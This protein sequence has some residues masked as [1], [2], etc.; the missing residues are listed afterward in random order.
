MGIVVI[1]EWWGMNQQIQDMALDISKR[2]NV[3]TIVP[4]LYRGEIATDH[5][6]AGHLMSGLDWQGA[7]L[8]IQGCAGHLIQNGCSKVGVIGF[9]MGGALSL[10]SA[11]L[12]PE[13]SAAA[14][15]YGICAADL[16]DVSK[17]KIPLQCHFGDKDSVP[18][19]SSKADQ[20]KL[21]EKLDAGGVKY[22]FFSYP[23]DHA[24]ANPTSA[25]FI[26]EEAEK[27]LNRSVEFFKKH[28]A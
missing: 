4:D 17:I 5:E 6:H 21:K 20:D 8:D 2:G 14:P 19:F 1:Q 7:V 12:V 23:A 10:A 26:K 28:L 13:I 27:A 11:V 24:F 15:F 18:G 9:C 16:A 3:T 25:N 22:E